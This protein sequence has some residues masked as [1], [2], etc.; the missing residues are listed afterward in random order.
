MVGPQAQGFMGYLI[1]QYGREGIPQGER[2]EQ[3]DWKP[4]SIMMSMQFLSCLSVKLKHHVAE[5]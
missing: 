1:I 5:V 3:R 2:E 4:R